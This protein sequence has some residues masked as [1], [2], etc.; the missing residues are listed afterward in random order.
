MSKIIEALFWEKLKA[1]LVLH[2]TYRGMKTPY[3]MRFSNCGVITYGLLN[4]NKICAYHLVLLDLSQFSPK[5][6]HS[7][8]F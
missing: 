2:T 4:L 7:H 1:R 8:L 6:V 5:R 3:I